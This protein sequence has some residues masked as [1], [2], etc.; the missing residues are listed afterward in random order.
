ME[1]E[2]LKVL[3]IAH[4]FSPYQ[5][6]ECAE[7]WNVATRLAKFHDVFVI[8]SSGSQ[9]EP[10]KYITAA[11]TYFQSNPSIPGLT[12]IPVTRPYMALQLAKINKL[13]RNIGPI[14]FPFIYYPGYKLWHKAAFRKVKQLRDE[15]TFHLIHLLTQ[16]TYREPGFLYRYDCPFVWGPTGGIEN[17]P[18]SFLS[19]FSIRSRFLEFLRTIS[20]HFVHRFSPRVNKAIKKASLIYAF[21][22]EDANYFKLKKAIRVKLLLDAGTYPADIKSKNKETHTNERLKAVWCGQLTDRKAPSILFKALAKDELT[23]N[24]LDVIVIGSGPLE[25]SSHRMATDL[26]LENIT[27][28]KNV[29]HDEVFNVMAKADFFIHTSL[30][31]ATSNVIPEA[32]S[33]GLPVLCHDANGM[34]IAIN[35]TCGIKIPLLSPEVSIS[36][37]HEAMKK[38]ILDRE[39]LKRLKEGASQRAREISWDVMAETIANDY[40]EIVKKKQ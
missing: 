11:D 15:N 36:G 7:G 33:V 30:R 13:F 29:D 12:L 39:M 40:L 2:R 10:G 35:E 22:K 25:D 16:I 1:N 17:I 9:F 8:F 18:T 28:M 26:G 24:S 3:V 21:S 23:R 19:V 37:F 32:L 4:E 5:G 38:L 20:N 27:W 14:G 34:S 6:S 31:E